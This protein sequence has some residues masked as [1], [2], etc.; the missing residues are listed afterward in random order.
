MIKQNLGNF[1]EVKE[2]VVYFFF[3]FLKQ[4]TCESEQRENFRV[5]MFMIM[6]ATLICSLSWSLFLLVIFHLPCSVNLCSVL[7]DLH[8]WIVTTT[9]GQG[10]GGTIWLPAFPT[11]EPCQHLALIWSVINV[12]R[13]HCACFSSAPIFLLQLPSLALAAQRFSCKSSISPCLDT[14]GISQRAIDMFYREITHTVFFNRIIS[15]LFCHLLYP[16]FEIFQRSS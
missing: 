15:C 1:F 9:D 10:S 12:S 7:V 13:Y 6:L 2:S 16:L 8:V 11:A 14:R 3:F 5:F 4:N